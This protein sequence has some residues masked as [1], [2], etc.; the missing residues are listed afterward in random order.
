VPVKATPH[1]AAVSRWVTRQLGYATLED[2]TAVGVLAFVKA[3]ALKVHWTCPGVVRE[4]SLVPPNE[5]AEFLSAPAQRE[6]IR[7][8]EREID[9][10]AGRAALAEL[11]QAIAKYRS[12][13]AAAEAICKRTPTRLRAIGCPRLADLP[14]PHAL[15]LLV[16]HQDVFVRQLQRAGQRL[17]TGGRG[18]VG[19]GTRPGSASSHQASHDLLASAN[20]LATDI[21]AWADGNLSL[22]CSPR[23]ALQVGFAPAAPP[24]PAGSPSTSSSGG[25]ASLS[26]SLS[27]GPAGSGMGLRSSPTQIPPVPGERGVRR[28]AAAGAAPSTSAGL[29]PPL[30]GQLPHAIHAIATLLCAQR[31][32]ALDPLTH[33]SPLAV[34]EGLTRISSAQDLLSLQ[35]ELE[36]ESRGGQNHSG[37]ITATQA[38][39]L[40][41]G[42]GV[43]AT[44]ARVPCGGPTATSRH[45]QVSSADPACINTIESW[46]ADAEPASEGSP[47][48]SSP[49]RVDESPPASVKGSS[50]GS[51]P[52][53]AFGTSQ[54]ASMLDGPLSSRPRAVVDRSAESSPTRLPSSASG[55]AHPTAASTQHHLVCALRC[56]LAH[57]VRSHARS[58]VLQLAR[59]PEELLTALGRVSASRALHYLLTADD[60]SLLQLITAEPTQDALA[61]Y[62][63]SALA[64]ASR[65]APPPA[66]IAGCA[67]A[68]RLCA[69]AKRA[70][71]LSADEDHDWSAAPCIA[72]GGDVDGGGTSSSGGGGGGGGEGRGDGGGSNDGR[73]GGGG[74]GGGRASRP[75]PTASSS[76]HRVHPLLGAV[77]EAAAASSAARAETAGGRRALELDLQELASRAV[78][79]AARLVGRNDVERMAI[80]QGRETSPANLHDSN[81]TAESVRRLLV[82]SISQ[83]LLETLATP[84]ASSHRRGLLGRPQ[85][86]CGFASS[87]DRSASFHRGSPQK[88]RPQSGYERRGRPIDEA[89]GGVLSPLVVKATLRQRSAST[90]A[91]P[92]M[93]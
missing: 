83:G 29:P 47:R 52:G 23:P 59:T 25:P 72:S 19:S 41:G 90:S 15:G 56:G 93:R 37:R 20:A 31:P 35:R 92:V 1:S 80:A 70:V 73:D 78:A 86:A 10:P 85:S 50:L 82:S 12:S 33:L 69:L 88:P 53:T 64:P 5:L 84:P 17:A 63:R 91:L 77:L 81:S 24:K 42:R 7:Q 26:H 74:V 21:A 32:D 38:Y 45:A 40:C 18:G 58:L 14:P 57:L 67:I 39:L 54:P 87:P 79:P 30:E 6:A 36:A 2:P 8:H 11:S 65:S 28:S 89:E 27:I 55:L 71:L 49:A 3:A 68:A 48:G 46:L 76:R 60:L 66:A 61:A 9:S 62:A 16:E 43:L 13:R 4:A 44:P 22:L 34:A 51:R 75:T